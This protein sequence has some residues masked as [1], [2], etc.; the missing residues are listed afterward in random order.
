MYYMPLPIIVLPATRRFADASHWHPLPLSATSNLSSIGVRRDRNQS[1]WQPPDKPEY[2]KQV[3]L[4]LFYTEGRARNSVASLKLQQASQNATGFPASLDEAF[5]W[6]GA[7]LVLL[8][9]WVVE[10]PLLWSTCCYVLGLAM[11]E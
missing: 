6:R 1:L 8:L 9:S 2:C 4:F 10:F 5:S 3:P 11:E 7:R